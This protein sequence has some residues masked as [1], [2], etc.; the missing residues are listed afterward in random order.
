MNNVRAL[1][2][3]NNCT[4]YAPTEVIDDAKPVANTISP[5]WTMTTIKIAKPL[6]ASI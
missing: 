2:M 4:P 1:T 6:K 5:A 3:K